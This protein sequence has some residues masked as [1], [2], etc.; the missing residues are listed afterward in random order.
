V[1]NNV[2]VKNTR[3]QKWPVVTRKWESYQTE[4]RMYWL[5]LNCTGQWIVKKAT[6]D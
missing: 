4:P 5:S 1:E 3:M 2:F 6:N